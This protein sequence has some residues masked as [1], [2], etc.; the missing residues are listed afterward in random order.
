MQFLVDGVQPVISYSVLVM[1]TSFDND[2]II[3]LRMHSRF[4]PAN[5]RLVL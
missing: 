1:S 2:N 5:K 4:V 3:R